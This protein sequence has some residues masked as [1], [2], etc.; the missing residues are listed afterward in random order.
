MRHTILY[1]PTEL[2][3]FVS[4]FWISSIKG[5]ND[6]LK[7]TIHY[8]TACSLA[9]IVIAFKGSKSNP[10]PAFAQFQGPYTTPQEVPIPDEGFFLMFGASIYPYAIPHFF[11]AFASDF[12][13]QSVPLSTFWGSQENV[14]T[15]ML[16]ASLS[17]EKCIT[18]L[19]NY[20]QSK[21][22]GNRFLDE[23]IVKATIQIR[24][25][26]GNSNMVR[27]SH[28]LSLSQKQFTRR[29]KI[30]TGFNPKLYAR[31]IRFESVLYNRM[32]YSNLT[33]AAYMNGYFDQAHCIQDF[34]D[35]TGYSPHKFFAI[36][37]L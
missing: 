15:D 3:D 27:L 22:S 1:P 7:S 32:E 12:N 25:D 8:S 10:C 17:S 29:F 18:I 30:Q 21:Q 26:K 37:P 13:N 31:I 14:F 19:S 2:K 16:A 36:A 28:E 4:H 24:E 11:N 34:K 33:E 20:L 6:D 5:Q 35:F 23:R 9:N